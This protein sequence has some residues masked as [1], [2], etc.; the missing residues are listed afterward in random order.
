MSANNANTN[1]NPQNMNAKTL[2]ALD[3]SSNYHYLFSFCDLGFTS[4]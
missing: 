3:I 4:I 1:H 2:Q